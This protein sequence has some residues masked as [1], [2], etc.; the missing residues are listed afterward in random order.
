MKA[1]A[2]I[3]Q[4][5]LLIHSFRVADRIES[6]VAAGFEDGDNNR[7]PKPKLVTSKS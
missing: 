1:T 2:V 5:T 6:G 7:E 4:L 3:E